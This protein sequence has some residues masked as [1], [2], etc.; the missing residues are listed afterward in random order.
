MWLKNVDLFLG[1]F[2]PMV[3]PGK[4]AF[5]RPLAVQLGEPDSQECQVSKESVPSGEEICEFDER[6]LW[7]LMTIRPADED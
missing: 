6:N 3:I 4:G 2:Q 1:V 7:L 5:G